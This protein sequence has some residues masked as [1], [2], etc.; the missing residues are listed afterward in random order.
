[1]LPRH[2]LRHY[3]HL[4]C[5]LAQLCRVPEGRLDSRDFPLFAISRIHLLQVLTVS[6]IGRHDTSFVR[7][8]RVVAGHAR[9]R[10]ERL[11]LVFF[12]DVRT[13]QQYHA[14]SERNY[15][16]RFPT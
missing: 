12:F 2:F 3:A 8:R 6:L 4:T 7:G 11:W 16:R 10:E 15:A 13:N 14:C 1:M 9:T 5:L